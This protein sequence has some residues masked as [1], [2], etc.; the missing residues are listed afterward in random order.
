MVRSVA[1]GVALSAMLVGHARADE[2]APLFDPAAV[3]EIDFG[4]TPE[5]R[6][7]LDADPSTYV[8]ATFSVT[9]NGA[10]ST[11]TTVGLRLRGSTSFRTMDGKASFKLKFKEFGG[12]K[13]LGLKK[14]TLNNMVQD[15]SMIHEELAYEL[16]RSQGVPAPRT[17]Y[18]YVRVNGADY[19]L[20]LNVE[21]LDDVSLPALFPSTQHLYEGAYDLDARP[22]DIDG[23]EVD[24]GDTADRSDLEALVAAVGAGSP[25]FSERVASV[26]DLAEMTRMWAVERYIGHWDGYSAGLPGRPPN[27]Y[28]LHSTADGQFSM[29]PWGTDQTFG[30]PLGFDAPGA[31]LLDGCLADPTC[32][33]TYRTDL[34]SIPQSMQALGLDARAAQLATTLAPWQAS[35]PRREY[36]LDDISAAVTSTRAFLAKRPETLYDPAFWVQGPPLPGGPTVGNPD[37]EPPETTL[38]RA[39]PRRVKTRTRHAKA[40]FRFSASES[41]ASF[42]CR[43]DDRRWTPCASPRRVRVGRGRHTFRV[44]ATD[45][46][47]NSDPTP[48][49]ARWKV[50]RR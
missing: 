3:A 36:S 11:P 12:P 14:L 6:A 25:S 23:F 31:V 21:T 2:A 24:E 38:D 43:L 39:P 26:A 18:A 16:F 1:I 15:E 48:A 49:L 46:T 41:A 34:A 37:A 50:K 17:G 35:D 33:A 19:G 4:L 20:Y 29:L 30:E 45:A 5:D 10:A 8:P 40:R 9:L 44:V 22:G 32:L 27:N 13:F 7:A 28:Y 42:Q 47:G